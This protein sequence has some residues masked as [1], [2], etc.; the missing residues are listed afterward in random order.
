[1]PTSF[2]AAPTDAG[3]RARPTIRSRR[4][5]RR[6]RRPASSRPR[7]A[8]SSRLTVAGDKVCVPGRR[9]RGL[10]PGDP[11]D[12]IV[13]GR[14][15]R[16]AGRR[17]R[18]VA[19][20]RP[21]TS[22]AGTPRWS[23]PS[24][25]PWPRSPPRRG[26][27]RAT[28]ATPPSTRLRSSSGVA[29][30]FGLA[31]GDR[32]RVRHAGGRRGRAARRATPVARARVPADARPDGAAGGGA[33]RGRARPAH[34]RRRRRSVSRSDSASR[35]CSSP[36]SVSPRSSAR[37]PRSVSRSTGRRSVL[38]SGRSCSSS[39]PRSRSASGWSAGSSSGAS[40]ASA[41]NR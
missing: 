13:R 39:G 31:L 11:D 10:V 41:R 35:S 9:D 29:G 32:P 4:S 8:T 24:S 30:G 40:C 5:C 37:P 1:M 3:A 22:C 20:R 2:A 33:D 27:I 26:S 16:I 21:T 7:S 38:W 23:R 15:V 14:A 12:G 6:T 34:P 17:D 18:T 28:T 25:R 36:D 19:S